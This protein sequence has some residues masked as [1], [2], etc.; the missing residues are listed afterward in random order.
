[1]NGSFRLY[2][3][4]SEG[5][6]VWVQQT[7]NTASNAD[8]MVQVISLF[9]QRPAGGAASH[10]WFSNIQMINDSFNVTP[11]AG[12]GGVAA[13]N[14]TI[15]AADAYDLST[16]TNFSV[17][18]KGNTNWTQTTLNGTILIVN[19]TGIFYNLTVF[20]KANGSYHNVTYENINLSGQNFQGNLTQSFLS[21]NVT[22]LL[23]NQLVSSFTVNTNLSTYDVSGGYILLPSKSG[24]HKFNVS[25]TSYPILSFTYTIS[26]LENLTFQA[27]VSPRFQFYLRREADNSVFDVAG[28]NTTKLNIFCPNKNIVITFRNQTYS[29][30]QE[31]ITMDC[32]YTFMKMDVSYPASSYFRSL[33]PE[34]SEQNITWWLLDLNQDTGVQINVQLVDLTGE[35]LNGILRVKR[36]IDKN[37]EDIIEQFFD[38]ESSV[39]L[40]LLKDAFYTISVKDSS[41]ANERQLGTMIADAAGTK[42]ITL[43]SIPFY[44]DK[45]FYDNISWAYTFN[46]SSSILRLQYEDKTTNTSLLQWKIYN[47]TNAT[48]TLLQTFSSTNP[49]GDVTFTY[50]G[51]VGNQ[52]YFTELHIEHNLLDFNITESRTFGDYSGYQLGFVGFKPE[53]TKNIKLYA[54]IIFLVVWGLLFSARHAGLGLTS[55]FIWVVILKWIGWF[56]ISAVWLG[57]IGLI[58]F[59]G[60]IVEAMKK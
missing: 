4:T 18:I 40:Y 24:F 52:T 50:N 6:G 56:P 11:Q 54:S 26:A 21:L 44:P 1:M 37:T 32:P 31:N 23:T 55:T 33:I 30:T 49:T 19:T 57:L 2:N 48:I 25:S 7:Q 60:W 59:F 43:P 17:E 13:A 36:A 8:K 42:T 3:E 20:S 35:F 58:A 15:T 46:T 9:D 5:S 41:G 14:L 12:G 22:D 53:D 27:N 51:V 34:K 38:I 47:G 29:S 10:V 28:T 45:V 39:V 16:L